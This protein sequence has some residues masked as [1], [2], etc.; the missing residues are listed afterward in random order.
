MC[1]RAALW[2][3]TNG[4]L[5]IR[6]GGT[7]ESKETKADGFVGLM[8]RSREHFHSTAPIFSLKR[9]VYLL[10]RKREGKRREV[11]AERT[12]LE[13]ATEQKGHRTELE[14][15]EGFLGRVQGPAKDHAF[16]LH[17]RNVAGHDFFS[18]WVSAD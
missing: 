9:E 4:S 6:T 2:Q 7:R 18:A 3:R 15:I 16:P 14:K 1:T 17:R 13:I 12:G 8:A 10:S 5:R 11:S